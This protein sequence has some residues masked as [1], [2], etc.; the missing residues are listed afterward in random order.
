MNII[1]SVFFFF[2]VAAT[3]AQDYEV[4][5]IQCTGSTSSTD[6][7]TAKIK[8]PVGFKGGPLFADDRAADP[9]TDLSCQIRP[10]P[11]DAQED[12][13]FLK[14]TDFTRCGV[15]K[16]NVSMIEKWFF[17][18]CGRYW[19]DFNGGFFLRG[20]FFE[21]LMFVKFSDFFYQFSNKNQYFWNFIL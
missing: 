16:R 14:V 1:E 21:I 19:W 4:S 13:Y 18:S 20:N 7:L 3:V 10:D 9:L 15:L 6:L 11:S 5:D 12:N 17:L 2:K 8:R